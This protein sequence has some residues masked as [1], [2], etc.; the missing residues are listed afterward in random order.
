MTMNDVT[1]GIFSD[2]I[3]AEEAI[4]KLVSGGFG[5]KEISIAGKGF[6]GEEKVVG[7]H[8]V[9]ERIV[10]WG[11]R[12]AFWSG[13]WSLFS[14]G[15]FLTLPVIGHVV[16]LGYLASAVVAAVDGSKFYGI[17]SPFGAALFSFGVNRNCVVEYEAV[18]KSDGFLVFAHGSKV[19]LDKAEAILARLNPLQ[20][21]THENSPVVNAA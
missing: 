6:R 17:S 4:K 11:N 7:F 19:E 18:L 13:L 1:I 10:F 8:N 12:G 20:L 5:I 16:F 15:V 3:S 2:Q 14:G 9:G 21:E